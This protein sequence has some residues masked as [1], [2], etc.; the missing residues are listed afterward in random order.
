[1]P[2]TYMC[3]ACTCAYCQ[4]KTL[5]LYEDFIF[6]LAFVPLAIDS[7]DIHYIDTQESQKSWARRS[8]ARLYYGRKGD[9]DGKRKRAKRKAD[10]T[11][12]VYMCCW[13]EERAERKDAETQKP[14]RRGEASPR[15]GG[16]IIIMARAIIFSLVPFRRSPTLQHLP[17]RALP[18]RE[19]RLSS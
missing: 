17:A 16:I 19:S 3:S 14:K 15:S 12:T 10:D 9:A 18:R 2:C 13:E 7:K 11:Y 1:M 6:N 8:R 5:T 4:M